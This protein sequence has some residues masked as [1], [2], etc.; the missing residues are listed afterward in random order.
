MAVLVYGMKM[1]TNCNECGILCVCKAIVED[2]HRHVYHTYDRAIDCPL[3]D[4]PIGEYV[5]TD[6]I[7]GCIHMAFD[8]VD[9]WGEEYAELGEL[10]RIHPVFEVGKDD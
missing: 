3:E 2:S 8:P 9:E 6:Q 5:T 4:V 1:P 7:E 10:R